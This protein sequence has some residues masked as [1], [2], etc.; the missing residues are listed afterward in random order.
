MTAAFKVQMTIGG[1][2]SGAKAAAAEATTAVKGLTVATKDAAAG[3]QT[4]VLALQSEANAAARL[5]S[6]EGAAAAAIIKSGSAQQAAAA[7][8][9]SITKAAQAATVGLG[10]AL[11]SLS[12]TEAAVSGATRG[13]SADMAKL[14]GVDMQVRS[15]TD[16]VVQELIQQ[17][18]A[19]DALRAEVAPAITAEQRFAA[20]QDQ[21][22]AAVRA[23]LITQREANVVVDQARVKYLGLPAAMGGVERGAFAA[24]GGTRMLGQ[25]L[26]QVAQQGAVTG[27]YLGALAVQL[28]DMALGFGGVAIAASIVATVA[29]PLLITAFG[30]GE[31]AADRI[32]GATDRLEASVDALRESAAQTASG[33]LAGLEE[34]YGKIDAALIGLIANQRAYNQIQAE[35]AAT[36]A[37]SGVNDEFGP[38]LNTMSQPSK[39]GLQAVTQLK[40]ELGLTA[41]EGRELKEALDAAL[42]AD[43]FEGKAAAMARVD[44]ILSRSAI[45]GSDLAISVNEAAFAMRAAD[46]AGAGAGVSIGGAAAGGTTLAQSLQSVG[47]WALQAANDVR[48]F[49]L[50]ITVASG[51]AAG[52]AQQ[53]R[54]VGAWAIEAKDNAA[55]MAARN[56]EAAE[57]AK[58][59]ADWLKSADAPAD[60][61][62]QSLMV[63]ADSASI[64]AGAGPVSGWMAGAIADVDSLIGKLWNAVTLASQMKSPLEAYNAREAAMEIGGKGRGQTPSSPSPVFHRADGTVFDPNPPPAAGGASGGGASAPQ[65]DAIQRFLEKQQ[66]ELDLLRAIDPVQK[67]MIRNRE[68]LATAT[69]A[70]RAAIEASLRTGIDEQAQIEATADAWDTLGNAAEQ[71]LEDIF[72]N[73]KK[74]SDIVADLGNQL[75]SATLKAA[76]LGEG[77]LAGLMGTAGGGGLIGGLQGLFGGGALKKAGGGMISGPGTGTSDDIPIWASNGE[78][79]V[80]AAATAKN[81]AALEAINAGA[82]LPA[83]AQGFAAGGYIGRGP[84]GG[85]ASG[86]S[87]MSRGAAAA[88]AHNHFY[89][90]TPNP[91]AFAE[92]RISVARGAQR[93]V[94][95]AGRYS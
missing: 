73:G 76:I 28:P 36:D 88:I 39:A 16:A 37:I 42:D 71:V 52:L 82:V 26:S 61:L 43:D 1:N 44:A 2:A 46:A 21:V 11:T 7:S 68:M 70:Q 4:H 79:M 17:S 48:G 93:L 87:A 49:S 90:T 54:N 57:S 45:S 5:T 51:E 64:L 72:L 80:T 34:K 50:P 40:M 38:M 65:P 62:G 86:M 31:S 27:D 13:L 24:G 25:Q 35:T 10:S 22:T 84:S 77:P 33:G 56:S 89:I 32:T 30:N 3:A 29:L 8:V 78:F 85:A 47:A 63:A 67:E 74:A 20:A 83:A 94:A 53:L 19:L 75:A 14:A 58:L 69:E 92:D 95:Q 23:G 81:R 59:F 15:A 12:A 41:R 66:Q 91:R 55:D 18:H 6:I 60:A 9:A